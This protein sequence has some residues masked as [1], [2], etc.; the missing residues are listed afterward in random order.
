MVQRARSSSCV[1][2]QLVQEDPG[3]VWFALMVKSD[4]DP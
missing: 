3:T 1:E 4:G 2:G